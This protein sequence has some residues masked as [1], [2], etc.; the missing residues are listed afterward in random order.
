[1]IAP[2]SDYTTE[3]RKDAEPGFSDARRR[4]VASDVFTEGKKKRPPAS[5]AARLGRAR[6][7]SPDDL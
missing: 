1:M 5:L 3:K 6:C 4:D 7:P 2:S